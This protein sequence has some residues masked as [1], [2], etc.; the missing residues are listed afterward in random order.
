MRPLKIHSA[1]CSH[2]LFFVGLEKENNQRIGE[3][4]DDLL[5][6]FEDLAGRNVIPMIPTA[7]TTIFPSQPPSMREGICIPHT[8]SGTKNRNKKIMRK[9]LKENKLN[10]YTIVR[11]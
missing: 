5:C 11:Y 6:L 7:T 3:N 8:L 1:M 2:G 9:L 10:L 4:D